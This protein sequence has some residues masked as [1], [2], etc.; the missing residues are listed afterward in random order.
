MAL[1]TNLN[2]TSRSFFENFPSSC[3]SYS[4]EVAKLSWRSVTENLI[5]TLSLFS[6]VMSNKNYLT[7]DEF[8]KMWKNELYLH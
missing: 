2:F 7:V 1:E 6:N 4:E 3:L 8:H 5:A